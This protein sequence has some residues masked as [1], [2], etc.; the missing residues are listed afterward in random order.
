MKV[1][2]YHWKHLV[3][4]CE[5]IKARIFADSFWT[6][7]GRII[8]GADN[9]ISKSIVGLSFKSNCWT[10]VFAFVCNRWRAIRVFNSISSIDCGTTFLKNN[11]IRSSSDGT[12]IIFSGFISTITLKSVFGLEI[13][14]DTIFP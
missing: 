6:S 2:N 9:W 14:C 10:W 8:F 3:A 1:Y 11:F 7:S 5:G 13:G 12:M 4:V